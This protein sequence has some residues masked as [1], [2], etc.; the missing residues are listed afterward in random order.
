MNKKGFTLIEL[1]IVIAI[2]AIIAGMVF[3]ALDPL[4]RFKDSRDSRRWGDVSAVLNAVK[5][6]QVDNKGTYLDK[7][8][9]LDDAK[10]YVIGTAANGCD[11]GCTKAPTQP[12]CVDLTGLVGEGYLASVPLDPKDGTV[13]KTNYYLVKSANGT[14]TVGACNPENTPAGIVVSR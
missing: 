6:D 11:A 1:L 7:I 2:I 9:G 14:V 3:V 5:V 4:K 10:A 13:A 8:T 12:A